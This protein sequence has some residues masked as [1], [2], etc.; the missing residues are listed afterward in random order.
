ME[1]LHT[2]LA[3][4]VLAQIVEHLTVVLQQFDGQV[5]GGVVLGDMLVGLQVFLDVGDAILNLVSVVDVQVARGLV[6]AFVHLDDGLEQLLH[7]GTALERR[8]DH[9]NAEQ[10]AQRADVHLIASTLK[11]VVHV[12]GANHADIHVHQLGRQIQV[13]LQVRGVDHVDHHVGHLFR[14]VFPH[15]EFLGR[16][17]TQ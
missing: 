6:R 8:G 5:S 4:H 12:Q 1:V 10:T 11:L 7:A 16:I 14:Q 17:A 15:I 3:G 9:R 13:T 2:V